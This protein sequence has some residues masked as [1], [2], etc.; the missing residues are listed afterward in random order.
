M[1]NVIGEIWSELEEGSVL[2]RPEPL[3]D[4]LCCRQTCIPVCSFGNLG[5][6]SK[7]SGFKDHSAKGS[8][9]GSIILHV[10]KP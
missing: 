5:K 10:I 8:F 7:S 2:E 9:F 3:Q 1:E 6:C 4:V